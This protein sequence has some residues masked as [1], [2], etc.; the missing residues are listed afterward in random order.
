MPQVHASLA[1]NLDRD[2][3][4]A[5]LPL[6]ESERVE[7]LEWSF[8]A[9]WEKKRLP[10]WFEALLANFAGAQR[11]VGHG[12][13]FSLFSGK[14]SPEQADWLKHLKRYAQRFPFDHV[15]EHF[16]F[17]TGADFHR[18]APLGV[19][20]TETTLQI[21]ID[22]L[23]R[24]Q[25]AVNCPVGL[26]NLAFAY[27][28]DTVAKH[29]AFLDALVESVNGFIILDLHNVYCQCCNFGV[30]FEVLLQRYPLHRVRELHLSGGSW[31]NTLARPDQPVRRDTH[32][33]AVPEAVFD[34]LQT[35][36]PLCPHLKF[37]VLEQLGVA[38]KT[39]AQRS[40]YQQDF[41]RMAHLVETFN[42]SQNTEPEA[43]HPFSPPVAM[44]LPA[45][46]EDDFLH[47]Q[48]RALAE[49]LET[50]QGVEAAR[51]LLEGSPLA[52]SDW[53]VEHWDDAMLE[54]AMAIAK[55]W[56]LVKS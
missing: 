39:E 23:R 10:K 31:E 47:T 50:S 27:D 1:C 44:P 11:L 5:A 21:G 48:Q 54:T 26:E 52:N 43:T 28:M 36:L 13:F 37:A 25:D 2:L 7:G 30:D 40:Q 51:A 29:G 42:L 45:P 9:L 46:L 17:M 6:L 32:D 38:L 41:Y 15:T 35:V 12:V 24:L 19:P 16:G 18:G 3:L 22:R 34:M 56:A 55:K 4:A 49:V 14:W 33:D 20:F 53:R 8:D